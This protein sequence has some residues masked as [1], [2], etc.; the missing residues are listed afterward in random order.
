MSS[1]PIKPIGPISPFRKLDRSFS[2]ESP[3]LEQNQIRVENPHKVNLLDLAS[4][5]L[6]SALAASKPIQK[7]SGWTKHDSDRRNTRLKLDG[8]VVTD[9]DGA[10][11]NIIVQSLRNISNQVR[12]VG[13]E[14][15]KEM[16]FTKGMDC[17]SAM[18]TSVRRGI[19]KE[20]DRDLSKDEAEHLEILQN[21]KQEILQRYSEIQ[22]SDEVT[23]NADTFN[24]K[25]NLSIEAESTRISVF[26]D[27]LDGTKSYSQG[28]Y[29]S[30]TTLVAIILDNVP[31]FGVICKPFGQKGEPSFLESGCFAVYGGLL[32]NGVFVAGGAECEKSRS[33]KL[34]NSNDKINMT[35]SSLANDEK[36]NRRAVISKSRAGGVVGRC[37][38]SLSQKGLL[39][40]QPLHIAGAGVKALSLIS[41]EDE[42]LWFFPLAGTSLWDIAALDALLQVLGG[43]ISDKHGREINYSKS[44]NDAENVD[45][46]IASNDFALHKICI[47]L[48][49]EEKWDTE[50]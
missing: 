16:E 17:M 38:D 18:S 15:R 31:I 26:V 32:L 42:S 47:N 5:A 11:Q 20:R 13:E 33:F 4:A 28:D 30:V 2:A 40:R 19:I 14:S 36:S 10:A 41:G 7:L 37:I 46:I 48:Y 1:N 49:H 34:R 8:T 22:T 9:A 27:P 39:N 44:R 29:D 45:G 3:T 50:S 24:L 35:S 12:I 6:A 23:N 25:K 21:V 43:K